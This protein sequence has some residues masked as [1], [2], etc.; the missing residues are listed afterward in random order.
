M[1]STRSWSFCSMGLAGAARLRYQPGH[2][3]GVPNHKRRLPGTEDQEC[4]FYGFLP[5]FL[6]FSMFLSCF[7]L[8]FYVFLFLRLF[9][10]GCLAGYNGFFCCFFGT[11]TTCR[12][13]DKVLFF[14]LRVQRTLES[15]IL[16]PSVSKQK[17]FI[18][19]RLDMENGLQ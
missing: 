5:F 19:L 9:V 16:V 8:V 1:F 2:P 3:M 14:W 6:R 15:T 17:A 10:D 11:L 18:L 7:P 4:L 12:W 13:W